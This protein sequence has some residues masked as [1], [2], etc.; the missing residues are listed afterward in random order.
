M[1]FTNLL[2]FVY[3]HK[4]VHCALMI[5]AYVKFETN[6]FHSFQSGC[7]TN[8]NQSFN[9]RIKNCVAVIVYYK[10]ENSTTGEVKKQ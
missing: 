1:L 3:L 2:I 5:A 8:V 9:E 6:L 7:K 10:A 4:K